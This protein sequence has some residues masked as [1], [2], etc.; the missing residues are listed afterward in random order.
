MSTSPSASPAPPGQRPRKSRAAEQARNTVN[1]RRLRERR[2][3]YI[4]ELERKVRTYEQNGV[5]ATETMQKAARLVV[6]ENKVL[7]R[8]LA[9]MGVNES[10]I[11]E[12]M[13]HELGTYRPQDCSTRMPVA[14]KEEPLRSQE[15]SIMPSLPP[16]DMPRLATIKPLP[17]MR[18]APLPPLPRISQTPQLPCFSFAA[19]D[20]P[21]ESTQPEQHLSQPFDQDNTAVLLPTYTEAH[22]TTIIPSRPTT[23]PPQVE[24]RRRTCGVDET[25]CVEAARIITS[26]RG[27]LNPEDVWPELGCSRETRTSV[28]N[29]ILMSLV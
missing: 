19:T 4:E 5:Q 24:T 9:E 23:A 7:R 3:E 29:T 20:H 25:D 18:L 22:Q 15:A 14:Y 28:K 16:I 17:P 27:G 6:E 26:L 10:R 13:N 11:K 2:K 12:Y 1:Q 8:M 21:L